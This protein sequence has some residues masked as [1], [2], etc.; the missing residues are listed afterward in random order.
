MNIS[1]REATEQ[2]FCMVLERLA[3]TFA[4]PLDNTEAEPPQTPAR[5]VSM[6]FD[7]ELCGQL[8]LAL[9][10]ALVHEMADNILG[11]DTDE[12]DAQSQADD[13]LREILN[14]TCGHMLTT[15]AG[16][17][18]AFA[19]SMPVINVLTDEQWHEMLALPDTVALMVEGQ[20]ALLHLRLEES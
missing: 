16:D 6:T 3:F 11:L 2:A 14:I 17:Q 7:G 5:C 9:P 1:L 8:R 12:E 19:L 10:A 18:P 15:L 13:A 20:A 4:E